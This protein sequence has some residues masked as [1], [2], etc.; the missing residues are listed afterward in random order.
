MILAF[1]IS[2]TFIIPG[3]PNPFDA[4][5]NIGVAT[6]SGQSGSGTVNAPDPA[7][8]RQSRALSTAC[9]GGVIGGAVTGAIIGTLGGPPGI[10]IGAGVGALA[11]GI[12]GCVVAA[13]YPAGTTQFLNSVG[14]ALPGFGAIGDFLSA[15]GTMMQYVTAFITFVVSL[16]LYGIILWRFDPVIGLFTAP[17]G[18]IGNFW[19]A[20]VLINMVRGR[21]G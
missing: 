18:I 6:D 17:I 16:S 12:I 14:G 2:N 20:Y 4:F 8:I 11:G 5:N 15:F 3:L 10:L 21:G 13:K 1:L 19:L 9:G 7:Q